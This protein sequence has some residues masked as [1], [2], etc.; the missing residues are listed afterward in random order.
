MPVQG[1]PFRQ[2]I[3]QA[4]LVL[5]DTFFHIL[6]FHGGLVAQWWNRGYQ[7]GYENFKELLEVPVA[8]ATRI[9]IPVSESALGDTP[10]KI[11][12]DLPPVLCE[13]VTC[14]PPCRAILNPYW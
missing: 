1:R 11:R 9:V 8:E 10:L 13:P 12:Q 5:F 7:E 2:C 6:I 14:K 4:R 3:H